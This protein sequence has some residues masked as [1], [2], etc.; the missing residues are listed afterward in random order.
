V[1][2]AAVRCGQCE[3]IPQA[4]HSTLRSVDR[5]CQKAGWGFATVRRD[6]SEEERVLRPAQFLGLTRA[7]AL[8]IAHRSF[9]WADIQ[10]ASRPL[11]RSTRWRGTAYSK[12]RQPKSVGQTQA[13]TQAV[14]VLSPNCRMLLC[15]LLNSEFWRSRVVSVNYRPNGRGIR[16][17]G[18][19]QTSST[20]G[21]V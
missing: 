8:F 7:R 5:S 18:I 13:R 16:T 9:S 11:L 12:T 15:W 6:Q 19:L 17:L 10:I 14:L 4:P 3:R 2:R 21:L 20:T 1:F